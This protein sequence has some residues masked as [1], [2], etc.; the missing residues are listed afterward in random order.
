MIRRHPHVFEKSENKNSRIDADQVVTNWEKIK[1][2]EKKREGDKK[3]ISEDDLH[4]P[5]LFAAHNIGKKTSKIGFD[6]KDATEVLTVVQSE[7]EEMK[8]EITGA[9]PTEK[10]Q[11]EL[12]DLLFSM[13]QLSRHLGFD[14]EETLRMANKKFIRRFESMEDLIIGDKKDLNDMN[15]QEMDVY[16]AK[17]KQGE[18]K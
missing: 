2:E 6:W 17:V 11:E 13:A 18:A 9:G 7:W 10:L 1:A 3:F 12:G 16:W 15:Q 5:A 8:D 4:H 14:P